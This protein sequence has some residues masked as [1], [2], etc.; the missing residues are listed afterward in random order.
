MLNPARLEEAKRSET[1]TA[2]SAWAC[3]GWQAPSCRCACPS[4]ATGEDA[5]PGIFEA[6]CFAEYE[7]SCERAEHRPI[8]LGV[9]GLAGGILQMRLPFESD[10]ARTLN[11]DIFEAIYFIACEASCEQA[12]R[13]RPYE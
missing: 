4:R 9:Q 13:E 8:G 12:E 3:R 1:S 2:R 5:Q 11:K 10:G 7:A 6:I